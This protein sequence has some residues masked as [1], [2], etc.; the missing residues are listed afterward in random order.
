MI[1]D[2]GHWVGLHGTESQSPPGSCRAGSVPGPR[3]SAPSAA[4]HH[5]TSPSFAC[6]PPHTVSSRTLGASPP[7]PPGCAACTDK[8]TQRPFPVPRPAVSGN[9][10]AAISESTS[11]LVPLQHV[12]FAPARQDQGL[13]EIPVDLVSQV[14]DVHV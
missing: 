7:W 3:E 5:R 1:A 8:R 14:T 4:G 10:G 9:K 6:N 11:R 2:Q 12:A 13:L